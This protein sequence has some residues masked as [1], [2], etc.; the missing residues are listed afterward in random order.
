ML[1][2]PHARFP[3]PTLTKGGASALVLSP[4]KHPPP[5]PALTSEINEQ[6]K[7][8]K[9]ETYQFGAASQAAQ[10]VFRRRSGTSA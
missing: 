6:R 3:K 5:P 10:R 1:R 2:R 9:A 4:K 8:A 7:A